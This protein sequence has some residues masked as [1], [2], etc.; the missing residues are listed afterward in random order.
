MA[1]VR[2]LGIVLVVL[3][4]GLLL[5]SGTASA[6]ASLIS[7]TPTTGTHVDDAPSELTLQLNEPVTLIEG[8]AQLIDGDGKTFDFSDVRVD[9]GQRRI[10]LVPAVTV[11]DG[12]YLATA[13]VVSADTH[14]VSLSI[15]FTVGSVTQQGKFDAG[16]SG[17]GVEQYLNYPAKTLAYLGLV[18][19]AGVLL[20]SL[21]VWRSAVGTTRFRVVYRIGALA[22]AL[23]LAGRLF[24]LV[25]QQSGGAREISTA[26]L[27]TVLVTPH[28][29]ALL[30]AVGLSM[31]AAGIGRTPIVF[32]LVYAG[33]A[34][35]AVTLSGHGG[36]AGGWPWAFLATLLHVYGMTVW[37]GGL[38]VM[39]LVLRAAPRLQRWHRIATVHVGLVVVAGLGLSLLQ[40]QP[41]PA[42]W[43]TSYG[44]V[45][46]AKVLA[47]A[48]VVGL[49]HLAYRRF[50]RRTLLVE[51]AVAVTVLA[52]TSI[53]SSHTPAKDVYTTNIATTLDFGSSDVL[54]IGID[55]I[56]RGPQQLT[57]TYEG[58]GASDVGVSADLSSVDANVARLPVELTEPVH[59]GDRT[60]WRSEHL[61][62]PAPGEWKVSIR[63]SGLDG[64][65][66]ASFFYD[67]M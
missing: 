3:A 51:T 33:A 21:L 35:L 24:V 53:L 26:G 57:V 48:F 14:V 20:S 56:R 10:V 59:D 54:D 25:A 49:G 34:I 30:V 67:A 7:T 16:E 50:R 39:L 13:R 27:G 65:K 55:S 62:V 52:L 19:T 12:A 5:G 6:H 9:D 11:Q 22:V 31:V 58:A 44:A 47:V 61:V 64:P 2:D 15:Q 66:V 1:R 41:L 18:A 8:S 37:L 23:G 40:V 29:S 28:G 38:A 63:F 17:G 45:L 36:S 60:I 43:R 32:G 4:A 46:L 42:L